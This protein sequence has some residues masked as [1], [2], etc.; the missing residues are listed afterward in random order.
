MDRSEIR[1]GKL[2]RHQIFWDMVELGRQI[3]A[4]PTRGSRAEKL[5]RRLQHLAA[6]RMR[7]P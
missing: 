6:R 1:D 2:A 5:S 7:Q 3:G 4:F